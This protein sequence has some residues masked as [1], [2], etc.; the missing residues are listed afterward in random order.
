[1]EKAELFLGNIGFLVLSTQVSK[2][3]AD[4]GGKYCFSME[5]SDIGSI[6]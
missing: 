2:N 4:F 5:N 1:M 6:A 3:L